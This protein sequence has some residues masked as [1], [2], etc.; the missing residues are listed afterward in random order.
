MKRTLTSLLV[1]LTTFTLISVSAAQPQG[2]RPRQGRPRLDPAAQSR[3]G[4]G[5]R[6]MQQI[7]QQIAQLQT[8]HKALINE[9]ETIHKIAQGEK[10][11]ETAARI[12]TLIAKRQKVHEAKL[13]R[14][15][16]QQ[17]NMER[18]TQRLNERRG[19]HAPN[20]ELDSF[21]GRNV[22]LSRY[23]GRVV[24][25]EWLSPDCPFSRYHYDTKSTMID[26]AKKY[27]DKEVVWLA[28]NSTNGTTPEANREFAQKHKLPYPILDDRAGRVGRA[29][30]ARTTPHV[31]V[32]DKDGFIAY[33]GAVDNAPMGKP[34]EGTATVNYVKEALAALLSGKDVET[35][36]TPP[37]GCS[38]KYAR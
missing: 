26:L 12:E 37:Y 25:L 2:R 5:E 19:R 18:L 11:T 34:G 36:A 3:A 30:G 6:R 35:P 28:V 21:D 9:L 4:G 14:L 16:R 7:R 13:A 29:Y 15:Q 27:R 8:E 38:V 24:V 23:K 1:I 20:F 31:F 22:S 33:N 32:I 10:A 17:E